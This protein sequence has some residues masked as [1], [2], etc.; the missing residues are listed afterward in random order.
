[1]KATSEKLERNLKAIKDA[2]RGAGLQVVG[3]PQV[4]ETEGK[5][6]SHIVIRI[7]SAKVLIATM[8]GNIQYYAHIF[9]GNHSDVNTKGF[10]TERFSEHCDTRIF[11]APKGRF[12]SYKSIFGL[13]E[14]NAN[15]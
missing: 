7:G 5:L 3:K 10:T 8:P 15:H 13:I 6:E 1:M 4:I 9:S 12:L 2:A 11:A 14:N